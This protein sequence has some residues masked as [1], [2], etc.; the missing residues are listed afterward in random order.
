MHFSL[1]NFRQ[2]KLC[3]SVQTTCNVEITRGCTFHLTNLENRFNRDPQLLIKIVTTCKKN[4]KP[5]ATSQSLKTSLYSC[6]P[7]ALNPLS[8]HACAGSAFS[9]LCMAKEFHME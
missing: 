7:L 2:F 9:C 4:A 1:Q 6:N 8:Q 5:M 3:M